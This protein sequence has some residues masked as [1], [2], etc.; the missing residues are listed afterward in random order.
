M[1]EA[2]G[3]L[4]S[5]PAEFRCV[6]TNGIV[7]SKGLVMGKGV[8]LQAKIRYPELPIWLG[9]MVK[10]GGN[11]AYTSFLY[12]IISFP[13]KHHWKDKSDLE[14]IRKS[15]IKIKN[16]VNSFNIKDV[17][18]PPPGCGNGGL[19]WDD[20]RPILVEYFDDRFTVLIRDK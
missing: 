9:K 11:Q 18:M 19:S 5:Y 15:C 7:T 3:N 8:A 12:K 13:T 20:V 4:W 10:F 2:K 16:M 1:L 6:T 17:V 14:L